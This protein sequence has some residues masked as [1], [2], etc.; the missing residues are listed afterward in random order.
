MCRENKKSAQL[1]LRILSL[2]V[3]LQARSKRI[4]AQGTGLVRLAPRP[5]VPVLRIKSDA[6]GR[7]CCSFYLLTSAEL[8][9]IIGSFAYSNLALLRYT[10]I[11]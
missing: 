10:T 2:H 9:V 3:C 5:L 11:S 8:Y 6:L 7:T 1:H 4:V